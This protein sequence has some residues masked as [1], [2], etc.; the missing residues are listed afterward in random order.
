MINIL[1]TFHAFS[2]GALWLLGTLILLGVNRTNARADRWLGSFYYMTA[3]LFTQLFLEGFHVENGALFHLLELP[4]WAIFPC[5]Y[6]AVSYLAEPTSTTKT[7][8]L[9]FVPFLIFIFFSII[10]LM[11]GFFNIA[12]DPPQLP[13][14]IVFIIKYF[15]LVQSVFYW[16]ACYQLFKKHQ[17]NIQQ[18]SS[19]TERIDL[20]WL[21]YLMIALL[22]LIVIRGLALVHLG[23]SSLSPILY[24]MGIVALAYF[25]LTQRSIYTIEASDNLMDEAGTQK[26]KAEERL[27]PIQ[28]DELKNSILQKTVDEKLYLDPGL[29]LTTL[30]NQVGVNPHDLSYILNNGLRKNFYQFINELRTEEAKKLL[31]SGEAKQLDM[32]G[33]A[34]RAGFNSR[35]TFYSCFK[36]ATGITPK[37]YIKVGSSK[38]T[39]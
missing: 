14:W 1:T 34:V 3:G 38:P 15:F 19:Y 26:K 37:E 29:T 16:I 6:L 21:K 22:F 8:A 9:H 18:L 17:K 39:V 24:F 32:F 36:K 25:A 35:T 5:F 2:A 10:Y 28:V 11:P 13:Q 20:A 7:W 27:T 30:S 31:L 33:I 4:R 12:V 23:I